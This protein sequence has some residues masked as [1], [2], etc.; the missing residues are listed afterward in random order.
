MKSSQ[1]ADTNIQKK[2]TRDHPDVATHKWPLPPQSE[3]VMLPVPPQ[4]TKRT[5][6]YH[7]HCPVSKERRG[8]K[9]DNDFRKAIAH[10]KTV[11]KL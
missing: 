6:H 11:A 8:R 1:T 3:H 7:K 5:L 4:P 2:Q 9:V 10:K